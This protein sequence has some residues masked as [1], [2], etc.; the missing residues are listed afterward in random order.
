[1]TLKAGPLMALASLAV[2]IT[3]GVIVVATRG[4]DVPGLLD[5][6]RLLTKIGFFFFIAVVI[7]RPLD[8]LLH[9]SSTSWL[10]ANRRYLGLSFASW[11]LMHWPILASILVLLGGPTAF[12]NAFH[13]FLL[14]WGG[15]ILLVITIM[16]ATSFDGAQRALGM[17]LWSAIHT[18]GLYTIWVF[19]FKIYVRRLPT[20]KVY[21][22][23]YIG[24]LVG[25][26]SLRLLMGARRQWNKWRTA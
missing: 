14:P 16:A 4:F 10:V 18:I 26:L 2:S 11:H 21:N 24:I 6:L 13:G 19:F 5:A 12:W 20:A 15:P 9:N 8:D 22:Y 3:C 7:C 1:M 23:W 25:A 17:R